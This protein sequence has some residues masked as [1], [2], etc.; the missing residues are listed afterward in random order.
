MR[1]LVVDD[2]ELLRKALGRGLAG[3]GHE[4]VEVGGGYEAIRRLDAGGIDAILTDLQMAEGD[5]LELI[6][7]ARKRHPRVPVIAMSGSVDRHLLEAA[8]GLGAR[9]TLAKPFALGELLRTLDLILPEP[10]VRI[11]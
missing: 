6:I 8:I 5:G 4:P 2:E 9:A 7:H 10:P 11:P 3:A 1:I